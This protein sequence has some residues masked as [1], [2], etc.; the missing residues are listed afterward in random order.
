MDVDSASVTLDSDDMDRRDEDV[1]M[2]NDGPD[3][4][5][6]LDGRDEEM[7]DPMEQEAKDEEME[8]SNQLMY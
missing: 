2:R 6:G 8:Q 3:G 1:I 4:P 5:D 7:S